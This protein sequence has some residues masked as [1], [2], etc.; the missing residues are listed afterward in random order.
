MYTYKCMYNEGWKGESER[1]IESGRER[2][3]ARKRKSVCFPCLACNHNNQWGPESAVEPCI[4]MSSHALYLKW[5][6]RST[7]E[8]FRIGT[9]DKETI[10]I[11]R[12]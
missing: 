7:S 4:L 9:L 10:W 8:P 2:E 1:S 12:F 3:R 6:T 5:Y 11:F